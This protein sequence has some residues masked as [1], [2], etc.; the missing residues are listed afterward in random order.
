MYLIGLTYGPKV[1]PSWWFIDLSISKKVSNNYVCNVINKRSYI[2]RDLRWIMETSMVENY[3]LGR[4]EKVDFRKVWP[5]EALDL[6]RWLAQEDN[7]QML[8]DAIGVELELV[9]VESSVGS[10][11]V[12]IFA[13]E[14]GTNRKII[15]ENQLEETNHDHLGKIITYASR[16]D[17]E[18]IIWIVAK[19]RDEHRQAIEWLNQH[20]DSNFGFFLIE[21]ELWKIGSSEPAPRFHIVEQPNERTKMVKMSAELSETEKAKLSYWT[22]YNEVARRSPQF[23]KVFNPQKPSKVH[24]ATL[25]CG[26]SDYH[27]S[28]LIDTQKKALASSFMFLIIKT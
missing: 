10:L 16:K 3:N 15:I 2:T 24:W 20:T 26:T 6:T 8:S 23:M 5:Y 27:I 19:A 25:R 21:I 18:V 22:K 7:L 12:D 17:A 13:S 1:L 11:S 4:I 14:A 28:L 9:E